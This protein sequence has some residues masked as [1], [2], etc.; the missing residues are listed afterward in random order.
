VAL[1]SGR[2][3]R[4]F[5]RQHRLW[6]QLWKT[7]RIGRSRLKTAVERSRSGSWLTGRAAPALIVPLPLSHPLPTNF[8][9]DFLGF[10]S[11][12]FTIAPIEIVVGYRPGSSVTSGFP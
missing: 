1:G 4:P 5:Y 12:S 6:Q 8:M 3:S 2:G 7:K 9:L 10:S 11:F